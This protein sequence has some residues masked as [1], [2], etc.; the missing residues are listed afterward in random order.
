M[1]LI[2]SATRFLA[3]GQAVLAVRLGLE[4][5]DAGVAGHVD[6][7]PADLR[8]RGERGELAA[9]RAPA[10]VSPSASLRRVGQDDRLDA[11]RG[12]VGA[13]GGT[14][15]ETPSH[16]VAALLT[17]TVNCSFGSKAPPRPATR[18]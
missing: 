12:R 2:S 5:A 9:Q 8:P 4:L 17:W 18:T 16:D 11:G 1:P 13:R 10:S 15:S 6:E 3:N 7:D 14:W